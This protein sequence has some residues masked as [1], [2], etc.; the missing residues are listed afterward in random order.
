MYNAPGVPA[1]VGDSAAL[2]RVPRSYLDQLM[3]RAFLSTY[4]GTT[5][6]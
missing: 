2:K 4:A 3:Q 1:E 6:Q 5:L